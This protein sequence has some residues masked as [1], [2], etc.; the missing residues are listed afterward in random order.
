ME[1][2]TEEKTSKS[3]GGFS[4]NSVALPVL[5]GVSLV[6]ILGGFGATIA[7]TRRRHPDLFM[8]SQAEGGRI[9][10][11]ALGWATVISCGGFAMAIL[12]VRT[13]FDIHSV[14]KFNLLLIMYKYRYRY[15]A[16]QNSNK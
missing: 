12:S 16:V 8:Q 5:V 11:R 4:I 2:K 15:P 3:E 9:A 14:R 10:F 7:L 1:K 13:L 6:S